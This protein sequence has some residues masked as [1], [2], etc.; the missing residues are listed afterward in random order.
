[1][2]NCRQSAAAWREVMADNV[3]IGQ[4]NGDVRD[5]LEPP[6]D[7]GAARRSRVD[8]QSGGKGQDILRAFAFQKRGI[9]QFFNIAR[10]FGAAASVEIEEEIEGLPVLGIDLLNNARLAFCPYIVRPGFRRVGCG[11]GIDA[12]LHAKRR[13]PD[14]FKYAIVVASD[15]TAERFNQNATG[16]LGKYRALGDIGIHDRLRGRSLRGRA[17][18]VVEG[19]LGCRIAIIK[20]IQRISD[21]DHT[22]TVAAGIYLV[23]DQL[24]V[25]IVADGHIRIARRNLQRAVAGGEDVARDLDPATGEIDIVQNDGLFVGVPPARQRHLRAVDIAVFD[26]EQAF[27]VSPYKRPAGRRCGE[28]FRDDHRGRLHTRLDK[29]VDVHI[30]RHD[31]HDTIG[32]H[33]G[34]A[35]RRIPFVNVRLAK[36]TSRRCGQGADRALGAEIGRRQGPDEFAVVTVFARSQSRI[37]PWVGTGVVP[38]GRDDEIAAGLDV[39][40]LR[41]NYTGQADRTNRGLD[42]DIAQ[43]VHDRAKQ[44]KIWWK[45]RQ[46]RGNKRRIWIVRIAQ[47]RIVRRISHFDVVDVFIGRPVDRVDRHIDLRGPARNTSPAD[48]GIVGVDIAGMEFFIVTCQFA[49]PGDFRIRDHNVID[50]VHHE[51]IRTHVDLHIFVRQQG[52][53][54]GGGVVDKRRS[55]CGVFGLNEDRARS[56]NDIR[57]FKEDRRQVFFD[58]GIVTATARRCKAQGDHLVFDLLKLGCVTHQRFGVAVV[59]AHPFADL[60]VLRR[61]KRRKLADADGR[62]VHLAGADD[63]DLLIECRTHIRVRV[64]PEGLINNEY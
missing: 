21:L 22:L 14:A 37:G 52:R 34:L 24:H 32:H 4:F 15:V 62:V 17:A 26:P 2:E 13:E 35:C 39:D 18:G 60:L 55:R 41:Q 36:S 20:N 8:A 9:A 43:V 57:D 19:S 30:G 10:Q 59:L 7:L 16:I 40:R 54:R 31:R 47:I 58:D 64:G 12:R 42:R 1:M 27:I 25:G 56:G 28:G 44:V 29:P 33:G 50:P 3:A 61:Q 63:G 11:K 48:K 49:E 38:V 51:H 5:V 6:D 45:I 53:T 23:R 46:G